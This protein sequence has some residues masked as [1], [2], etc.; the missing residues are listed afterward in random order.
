M[1]IVLR[2][3]LPDVEKF[4]TWKATKGRKLQR[5]NPTS[6]QVGTLKAQC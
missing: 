4:K 3:Y 6:L 2:I 5:N 1:D